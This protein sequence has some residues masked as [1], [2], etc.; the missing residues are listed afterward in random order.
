[1]FFGQPASPLAGL[2]PVVILL[3]DLSSCIW[4]Q[5][6]FADSANLNF[7]IKTAYL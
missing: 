6:V 4:R 2:E 7:G 3:N 1:M 5:Y